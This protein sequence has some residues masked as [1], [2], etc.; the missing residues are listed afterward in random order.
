MKVPWRTAASFVVIAVGIYAADPDCSTVDN[1]SDDGSSITYLSGKKD[2]QIK[3]G[4]PLAGTYRIKVTNKTQQARCRWRLYVDKGGVWRQ[5]SPKTK[6]EWN[7][8]GSVFHKGSV[9]IGK[10]RTMLQSREC[11]S[12][13][14][15]K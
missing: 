9:H 15:R 13:E 8:P 14:R 3:A 1:Q 6:G 5:S 7:R 2:T 12:W 11:P 10:E 4:S